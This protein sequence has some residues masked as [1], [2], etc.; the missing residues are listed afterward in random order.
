MYW[1]VDGRKKGEER[2]GRKKLLKGKGG[3][4]GGKKR[5]TFIVDQSLP[6]PFSTGDYGKRKEGG[7]KK[8]EKEKDKGGGGEAP[9]LGPEI[10]SNLQTSGLKEKEGQ[11]AK[12]KGRGGKNH[13]FQS[14]FKGEKGGG[15][16]MKKKGGGGERP[17]KSAIFPS[18]PLLTEH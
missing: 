5:R 7:R 15:K 6:F 17:V 13:A 18:L 1:D 3:E 8:G 14:H 9:A 12:K 2:W 10:V 16:G 11:V 4:K